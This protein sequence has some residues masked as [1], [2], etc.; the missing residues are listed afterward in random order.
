MNL[1][2]I[3]TVVLG[4]SIFFS[5]DVHASQAAS[6]DRHPAYTLHVQ[7]F[8]NIANPYRLILEDVSKGTQEKEKAAQELFK[9]VVEYLRNYKSD[10]GSL[11]HFLA[12]W[13]K[14]RDNKNARAAYKSFLN[15]ELMGFKGIISVGMQEPVNGMDFFESLHHWIVLQH[16][17][18]TFEKMAQLLFHIADIKLS[19]VLT[20][21]L[22]SLAFDASDGV[23][24]QSMQVA[25]SSEQKRVSITSEGKFL[26]TLHPYLTGIN[27]ILKNQGASELSETQKDELYTCGFGCVNA[28]VLCGMDFAAFKEHIRL[29]TMF[30]LEQAIDTVSGKKDSRLIEMVSHIDTLRDLHKALY[31]TGKTTFE[32]LVNDLFNAIAKSHQSD[33][34]MDRSIKEKEKI[35][36]AKKDEIA[37]IKLSLHKGKKKSVTEKKEEALFKQREQERFAREAAQKEK[38]EIERIAKEAELQEQHNRAQLNKITREQ[39]QAEAA[40]RKKENNR[41]KNEQGVMRAKRLAALEKLQRRGQTQ[42]RNALLCRLNQWKA[43]VTDAQENEQKLQQAHENAKRASLFD[44]VSLKSLLNDWQPSIQLVPTTYNKK[45]KKETNEQ[46]LRATI[47][48]AMIVACHTGTYPMSREI[49][50]LDLAGLNNVWIHGN[51]K[52]DAHFLADKQYYKMNTCNRDSRFW[53]QEH[54]RGQIESHENVHAFVPEGLQLRQGAKN[55]LPFS[56]LCY[57]CKK[58]GLI[59]SEGVTQHE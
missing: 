10:G 32:Q 55:V 19:N 6:S 59:V 3:T 44:V 39:A 17:T 34:S 1:F 37:A 24:Q 31:P 58:L 12:Y 50:A 22:F 15:K 56:K 13:K 2:K 5:S 38:Q 52:S 29:S 43:F 57:T 49:D 53:V 9:H 42:N 18:C 40:A 33:Q 21:D 48:S 11:G 30:H 35:I 41:L 16:P 27:R 47:S 45:L 28:Y 25:A 46:A 23:K 20:P 14:N 7:N 4:A 8:R 26:L 51:E 54:I 36:A